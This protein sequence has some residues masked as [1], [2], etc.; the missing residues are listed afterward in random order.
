MAEI[1]HL[2]GPSD[3]SQSDFVD[4][5]HTPKFATGLGIKLHLTGLSLAKAVSVPAGVGVARCRSTVHYWVKQADLK[6]RT[7][8]SPDKIALDE[9]VVKVDGESHWLF[10]AVDPDTKVILHVGPDAA[11]TTVA[12]K[13]FLREL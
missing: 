9:T 1:T 4:R 6:Q 5:I 8:R 2:I 3:A 12:T 13:W 11:R 7:G 10:A